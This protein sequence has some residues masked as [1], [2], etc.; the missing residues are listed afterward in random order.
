VIVRCRTPLRLG[1]AG[2]GTDVSPYCD[3]FGGAVLNAT[4]DL[5]AHCTIEPSLDGKIRFVAIDRNEEVEF[6]ISAGSPQDCT[7]SLH[8][9]AYNRIVSDFNKGAPLAVTVST[10]CEAPAGSGLGSSSTLVVSMIQAYAEYL[11]LGLGD[12]DVATE[13]VRINTP[14]R[15][16]A[17]ILWSS[18]R[19][20]GCW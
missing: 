5:Y 12:Y 18:I 1:L 9:A 6:D 7:L 19:M 17:S 15:L 20:I 2:G 11:S 3:T 14:L 8:A 16:V 10:Y 4:I 13:G